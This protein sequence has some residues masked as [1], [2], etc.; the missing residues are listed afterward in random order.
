MSIRAPAIGNRPQV[1]R[2]RAVL[3]EL[4]LASNHAVGNVSGIWFV[5]FFAAVRSILNDPRQS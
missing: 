5:S 4:L 2:S 1:E 3:V